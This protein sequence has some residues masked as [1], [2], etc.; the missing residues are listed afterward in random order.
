MLSAH[1]AKL[2][3]IMPDVTNRQIE[4]HCSKKLMSIKVTCWQYSE[5]LFCP[6]CGEKIKKFDEVYNS[7]DLQEL[8]KTDERMKTFL[9]ELG[10]HLK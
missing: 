4:L 3:K 7:F 6:F 2:H 8:C 10:V 1:V 5:F 9:C